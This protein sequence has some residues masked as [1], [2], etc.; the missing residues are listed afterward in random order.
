MICGDTEQRLETR[1]DRRLKYE[2]G[3]EVC[4]S[5]ALRALPT[6][7]QGLGLTMTVQK[8]LDFPR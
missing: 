4:Q 2:G 8:S 5:E 1:G 6:D 7:Q 3:R